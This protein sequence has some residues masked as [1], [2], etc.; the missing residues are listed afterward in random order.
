MIIGTRNGDGMIPRFDE[1]KIAP[2]LPGC[3][4]VGVTRSSAAIMCQYRCLRWPVV[5]LA[6]ALATIARAEVHVEGDSTA[7]RV[8]TSQETIS[9]V[10]AALAALFIS[11]T[12]PPFVSTQAP[13]QSIRARSER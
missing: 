5:V 8:T 9:E 1:S 2:G 4:N 3:Q 12:A 6:C 10:L 11:S 7:A 13:M